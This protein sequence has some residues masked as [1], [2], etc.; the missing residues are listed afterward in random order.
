VSREP[1][2]LCNALLRGDEAKGR[3]CGSAEVQVGLEGNMSGGMVNARQLIK[4][5]LGDVYDCVHPQY[6]L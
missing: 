1:R 2:P 5:F 4:C 6:S 3:D